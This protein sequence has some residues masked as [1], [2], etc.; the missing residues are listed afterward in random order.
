MSAAYVPAAAAVDRAP[1]YKREFNV[2]RPV[3]PVELMNFSRQ[4]ASFLRSGIQIVD[5]LTVIGEDASSPAMRRA[6]L[7]IA[8]QI[9][10]GSPF[11]AAL[12]DHPRIFPAYYVAMTRA[13]ESTG[14]LDQ[15]LGQLA[16]YLFREIEA[17]R[18]VKSALTYPLIVFGMAI[19]SVCVL[20]LW[21]LPKFE[22][23]FNDL[24]AELPAT[25]RSLLA[26]TD[27]VSSNTPAIIGVIVGV[28][29]L[30]GILLGGRRGKPRRDPLILRL[31][32]FGGLVQY[33]LVERFC[34][35]LGSLVSAGVPLPDALGI[36][37]DST[38]NSVFQSKLTTVREAVIG[39]SGLARP[40]A[41]SGLFPSAARQMIRVGETTGTL[42]TQLQ[43]A[44][45]FYEG[46][47]QYRLKRVTDLF[48][49]AI[50]AVVGLVVGFIALALVSAMY[51]V[52]DQVN[53]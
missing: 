9:R 39:G 31:P 41:G 27:F 21:V 47:L 26:L 42:D 34:R 6:L 16:T 36:A 13:A 40:M 10:N 20:S 38:N 12:A 46:E 15:I 22:G 29:A 8:T 53:V 17:R 32:V 23:L 11:A 14:R 24:G 30:L 50:I 49:P 45:D 52:F 7:S 44:A 1:W 48:E 28:L 4:M 2:R 18:K 51:G 37:S 35:V 3:K 33:V 25:T 5:A 19:V 43:S